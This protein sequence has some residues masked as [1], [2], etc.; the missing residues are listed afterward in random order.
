MEA[1]GCE[2]VKAPRRCPL[3]LLSVW[4]WL[5]G[6]QRAFNWDQRLCGRHDVLGAA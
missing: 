6:A 1:G 3:S 5:D 2:A 4:I